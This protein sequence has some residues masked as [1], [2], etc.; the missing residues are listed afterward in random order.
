MTP[1]QIFEKLK[2]IATLLHE[3][4]ICDARNAIHEIECIAGN[5]SVHLCMGIAPVMNSFVE[6][7]TGPEQFMEEFGRYLTSLANALHAPSKDRH[8]SGCDM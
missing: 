4:R 3:G 6:R 8:A 2:K 7:A 5:E 1:E